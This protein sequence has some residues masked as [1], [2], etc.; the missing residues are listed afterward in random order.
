[1]WKKITDKNVANVSEETLNGVLKLYRENFTEINEARFKLYTR[2]FKRTTYVYVDEN[3]VRG[4]C[5]YYV[6][7]SLSKRGLARVATLYSFTV[8][9]KYQGLGIGTKLLEKSL[10]EMQL[11]SIDRVILY[12]AADN[13]PA[14]GLYEKM[15]FKATE[16]VM[17]VCGPGKQC[18]QME[19]F[20]SN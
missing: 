6:M 11:H 10:L 7:A 20:F 18:Y 5:L 17:D 3:E 12:V 14:I 19:L 2:F 13:E 8:D 16:E 1:M 4:Y 9:N 15:G